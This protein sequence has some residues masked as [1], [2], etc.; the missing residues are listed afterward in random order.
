MITGGHAGLGF[1]SKRGKG[2]GSDPTGP[3]AG[4]P[5]LP[6]PRLSGVARPGEVLAVEAPALTNI[7]S[8]QWF[9]DDV[10]I[11]EA[12]GATF[13]P[14]MMGHVS[15]IVTANEGVF[16]APIVQVVHAHDMASHGAAEDAVLALVPHVGASHIAVQ[17]G[18]WSDPMTWDVGAVPAEGAVVLVPINA[19]VTYDVATA[20]R[21]DRLRLDGALRVA[22]DQSTQMHVETVVIAH[23]GLLEIGAGF[24]SRLPG[25]Y[26]FDLTVSDRAY[27]ISP[28]ASS[29]LDLALDPLL[30]G[31]GI[32]CLGNLVVFGDARKRHIKTAL[33]SAP[34]AGD[35]FR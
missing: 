19:N 3:L 28:N 10:E 22:L 33:G 16:A 32:V 24:E 29:D 17:D 15:A 30:L 6:W 35:T 4:R 21:L 1:F 5:T 34:L 8:Y 23:S 26:A 9:V 25:Q 7:Q 27:G 18:L 12:T 2:V 20:P 11:T 31:R 13:T 14:N